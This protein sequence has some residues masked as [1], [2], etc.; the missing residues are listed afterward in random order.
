[1][2]RPSSPQNRSHKLR[3]T[4]QKMTSSRRFH[5]VF[6]F[7]ASQVLSHSLLPLVASNPRP[8]LTW[9]HTRSLPRAASLLLAGQTVLRQYSA[10]PILRRKMFRAL[11]VPCFLGSLSCRLGEYELFHNL[12]RCFHD[13]FK[14]LKISINESTNRL[15]ASESFYISKLAEASRAYVHSIATRSEA[16]PP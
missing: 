11:S 15:S 5:F 13:F 2:I 8:R 10:T 6:T 3:T 9:F 4:R 1:M 7:S 12:L 14:D 16:F